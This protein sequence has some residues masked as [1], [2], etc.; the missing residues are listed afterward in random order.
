MLFLREHHFVLHRLALATEQ[1]SKWMQAEMQ[2]NWTM[3]VRGLWIETDKWGDVGKWIRWG[4]L[5][6]CWADEKPCSKHM[7][8]H[9]H[10]SI[11]T[12]TAE[13][14]CY[15]NPS[16]GPNHFS[17]YKN[18][19]I[20]N[21]H[22]KRKLLPLQCLPHKCH[23]YL[24]SSKTCSVDHFFSILSNKLFDMLEKGMEHYPYQEIQILCIYSSFIHH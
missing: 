24:K 9:T 10:T 17:E 5:Y 2:T 14:W 6:Q 20:R 1:L 3:S 4:G 13:P 19:S 7:D 23:P 8:T 16:I 11:S 12:K 15:L 18:S 21:L 22:P